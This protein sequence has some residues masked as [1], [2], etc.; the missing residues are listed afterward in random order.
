MKALSDELQSARRRAQRPVHPEVVSE[1]MGLPPVRLRAAA[2]H[3]HWALAGSPY[4]RQWRESAEVYAAVC[5]EL[6]AREAE[7]VAA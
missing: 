1:I 7:D 5:E 3:L 2:G 4:D 6:G